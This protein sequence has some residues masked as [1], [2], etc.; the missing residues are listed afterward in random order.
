MK[1]V[2]F[3]LLTDTHYFKNELGAEGEA[4]EKICVP[5]SSL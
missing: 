1:P 3:F 2:N 5:N 4:F